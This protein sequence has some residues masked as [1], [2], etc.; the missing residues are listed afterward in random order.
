M[1]PFRLL[2]VGKDD[3]QRPGSLDCSSGK[4]RPV[5]RLAQNFASTCCLIEPMFGMKRFAYIDSASSTNARIPCL[6][7]FYHKHALRGQ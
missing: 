7:V 1:K 2:M 3:A 4:S 5:T 6:G